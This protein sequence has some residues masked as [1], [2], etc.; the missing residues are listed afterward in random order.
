MLDFRQY[1]D[2]IYEFLQ[3]QYMIQGLW[4]YD[5]QRQIKLHLFASSSNDYVH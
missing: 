2:Y 1:H 5:P 4:S 3:I